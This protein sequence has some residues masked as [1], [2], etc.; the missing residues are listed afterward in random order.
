MIIVQIIMWL[1]FGAFSRVCIADLVNVFG[2]V[3]EHKKSSV[4]YAEW[5]LQLLIV[6]CYLY[7]V[8]TFGK[9]LQGLW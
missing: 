5:L 4:K 1:A 9:W 2:K 3:E 7:S 8:Y 6:V